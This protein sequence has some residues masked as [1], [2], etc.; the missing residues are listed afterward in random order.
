MSLPHSPEAEAAVLA[1]CLIAPVLPKALAITS[2]EDFHLRPYRLMFDAAKRLW[3]ADS[4]I[5]V[6]TI[7]NELKAR[8]EF[9][10]VGGFD[11]LSPLMDGVPNPD[12]VDHHAKIVFKHARRRDL[13]AAAEKVAHVAH[14]TDDG[15]V[16]EAV[17]RLIDTA[18]PRKGGGGFRRIGE[19]VWP[20]MEHFERL[21][22]GDK[23]ARG[24]VTGFRDLDRVLI[25]FQ[26]GD[27][28]I[29]A[30]RPS[31]GKTA[32]ALNVLANV[33]FTGEPVALVSLEMSAAQV[34]QRMIAAEARVDLQ[35]LRQGHVL[36]PESHERLAAAA[37]HINSAPIYIDDEPI[38]RV[39]QI[40]AKLTRLVQQE[41]VKLVAIDYV[42]LMSAPKAEN[43][44]QE[45]G[46]I[47][48]DLKL[49][50]GRLDVPIILLSQLSR[51]P[52][53]RADK[54]PGLADLRESGS[55]EQDADAVVFLYRPEYYAKGDPVKEEQ[56]RGMADVI[57]EKQRNGPTGSVPVHFH[58]EYARFDNT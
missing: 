21:Q 51:G 26:G 40:A 34:T 23:G 33:A 46:Q 28:C 42:Q 53:Q 30:A 39:P 3:E 48:R 7:A 9:E 32:F 45:V 35:M 4:K 1:A 25:G 13:I 10:A 12:G 19:S 8:G 49:L 54:R 57:V 37:G 15:E 11:A 52:E 43:R 58:K 44:T 55:L 2:P 38:A 6:V 29:V 14:G 18:S 27:L 17:S 47:S 20:A 31:M 36:S 50:A 24:L 56:L 16:S 5:D 41:G 22:S